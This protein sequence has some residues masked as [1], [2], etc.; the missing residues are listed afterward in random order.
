MSQRHAA[1]VEPVAALPPSP[2]MCLILQPVQLLLHQF[3]LLLLPL[4]QYI[5]AVALVARADV[6]AAV[7]APERCHDGRFHLQNQKPTN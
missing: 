4:L 5:V 7:A 3:D 1:G 2:A 6:V